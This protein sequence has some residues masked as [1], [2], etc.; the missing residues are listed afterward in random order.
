M[1]LD[2]ERPVLLMTGYATVDDAV[3][4]MRRGAVDYIQKLFRNEAVLR[5][6]D[7]LSRVSNLEEENRALRE[8]LAAA[9]P[10]GSTG[11]SAPRRDAGGLRSRVDRGG[12]RGDRGDRGQSGT[13]KDVARAI[14]DLSPRRDG[15]FIALA[16]APS[17][18]ICWRRSSSGT[19]RPSPAR[20]EGASSRLT[21]GRCSSMTS[22][23][24]PPGAGALRVLQERQFER[25]GGEETLSLTSASSLRRRS[26][27]NLV[28]EGDS[29]RTC[30]TGARGAG[31]PSALRE[32]R[33]DVP[34]LLQAMIERHG[35]GR[36]YEVTRSS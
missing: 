7:T 9:G 14:H 20:G 2:P 4:A 27:L 10:R 36:S 30:S 6:L 23:T 13:G 17:C 33:G 3:E 15:P 5:R 12:H 21:E 26:R 34:L 16:A 24:C 29:A 8:K 31:G 25:V 28:R 32:R 18:S 22:T 35:G 1:E 11:S 19:R